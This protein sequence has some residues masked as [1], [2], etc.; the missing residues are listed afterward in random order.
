MNN[1]RAL[2]LY[3]RL[4]SIYSYK[5]ISCLLFFQFLI[6]LFLIGCRETPT[7]TINN[8]YYVIDDS[9]SNPDVMPEVVFTNPADGAVGP[10][11]TYENDGYPDNPLVT[12]QFNKLINVLNLPSTTITLK[13]DDTYIPL[14]L[15]DY[16]Y[17]GEGYQY[18]EPMLRYI[19]IF[20]IHSKYRA[21][22]S[23]TVTVDTTLTDVHGNR[24]S[25]PYIFTFTPEPNFRVYEGY[26]DYIG[27]GTQWFDNITIN[28]NS[29]VDSTIFEKIQISPPIDGQWQLGY[30]YSYHYPIDSTIVRHITRDTLLFDTEY[31][32][33]VAGDAHDAQGHVINA[34][35]QFSFTTEPFRVE[36]YSYSTNTSPEGFSYPYYIH[37]YFNGPLDTSTVRTAINVTPTLPFTISYYYGSD[38]YSSFYIYLQPDQ[39]QANT[40]YKIT[41]NTT[42]RSQNGAYM[43]GPFIFSFNTYTE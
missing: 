10:F 40:L 26:P 30:Y 22:Q 38:E 9:L 35:Y 7:D 1:R 4:K 11:N 14:S 2:S 34:P 37:F 32:I 13:F 25:E 5:W 29:S 31:T 42:I 21:Y 43:K 6:I 3:S 39:M 15:S 36:G 17:N 41:L 18:L 27:V 8:T 23:Y 28:F 16:Y 20:E 33:S 12:I 24:F 19:L